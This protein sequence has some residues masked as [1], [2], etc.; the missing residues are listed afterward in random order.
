MDS[1]DAMILRDLAWKPSDP[2][3]A[4]RGRLNTWQTARSLGIHGT[5]VK[6]RLAELRAE[7]TLQ[8]VHLL[9]A[10]P[11][12]GRRLSYHFLRWPDALAKRDGIE[13]LRREPEVWAIYSFLGEEAIV[14]ISTPRDLDAG[15]IAADMAR[16]A[17]A[18]SCRA[19]GEDDWP[20]KAER[21]SAL[22]LRILAAMAGD[23]QKPVG[24]VAAEVGVTRKTVT[25]RLKA[26]TANRAFSIVPQVAAGKTGLLF[27]M[28]ITLD[29]RLAAQ[30]QAALLTEFRHALCRS[31]HGESG[32]YAVVPAESA[33]ALEDDLIK[34][35]AIEGVLDVRVLVC[36]DA[37]AFPERYRDALLAR[38]EALSPLRR[39]PAHL[40]VRPLAA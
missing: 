2:H 29:P 9:P 4:A 12:L 13:R 8:G 40:A 3:H 7:G 11:V 39:P 5:T 22:D 25:S 21:V 32:A 16:D 20:V 23:A 14:G 1:L 24:D 31:T 18:E 38:S 34:A 30:A 6:R 27:F 37:Y 19:Q 36:S 15:M 26:L 17:G 33:T 28:D 35:Q 10:G